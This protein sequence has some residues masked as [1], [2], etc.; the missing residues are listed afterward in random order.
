MSK[1]TYRQRVGGLIW[2]SDG[3]TWQ[4][5]MWLFIGHSYYF[6]NDIFIDVPNTYVRLMG[7]TVE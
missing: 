7:G 6:T 2:R 5:D 3:K 4:H 1:Y